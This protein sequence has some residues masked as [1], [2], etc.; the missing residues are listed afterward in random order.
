MIELSGVTK[1]Y[2]T[3][4]VVDRVSLAIPGG[5]VTALIGPNGAGKS[6]LLSMIGRLLPA[7]GGRI[8]VDGLDVAR[9]PGNILARKLSILR[10]ENQ[11]AVRLTVRE[12][13]E[14]GRFPYSQGRLTSEDR[15]HVNQAIEFLEL[16]EFSARPI[17]RLSGGQRQRAFIAMVLCQDTDYVL[18]DE[19][20]NNLDMRHASQTMSLIRRL[21]TE[22]GKTIVIVLHD[23][24]FASFH[25]DRV[26][27][28][29]DG[30]IVADGAPREVIT[31]AAMEEI[32]GLEVP[33]HSFADMPVV[34]YFAT[35]SQAVLPSTDPAATS[36][37]PLEC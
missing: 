10:Q 22:L 29:K 11:V 5:G 9:T 1:R 20:L 3:V 36:P 23:V 21:A 14:F 35:G 24:N 30:A 34:A 4:T 13:V 32:F 33:V 8:L 25:A 7:D 18:L 28:M 26:I 19:P 12:L 17:N 37:V 2:G 6:T 31:A 16:A 27:A 15:K